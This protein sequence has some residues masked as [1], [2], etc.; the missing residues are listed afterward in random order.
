MEIR[1]NIRRLRKARRLSQTELAEEIG[2][3]TAAIS[4]YET[5]RIVPPLDIIQKLA[6]FFSVPIVEVTG[7]KREYYLN[8]TTAYTAQE[9]FEN[10]DLRMLFDAAR[11]SRPEDLQMAADLLKRLKKTNL[12]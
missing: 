2:V 7:D 11:D 6:E 3:S 12:D 8:E 4:A 9:L 10:P 5:G 1:E